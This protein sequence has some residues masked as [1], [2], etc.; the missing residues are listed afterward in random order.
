MV[1][2]DP[3]LVISLLSQRTGSDSWAIST[4]NRDLILNIDSGLR[5]TR[6]TLSALSTFASA[7]GLREQRLDPGFVHEVERTS[8]GSEEE[9]VEEDAASLLVSYVMGKGRSRWN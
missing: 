4:N 5:S 9:E 8:E 7:T 2:R 3:A 6:G 1:L